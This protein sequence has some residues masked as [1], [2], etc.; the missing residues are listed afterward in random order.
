MSL[1][2]REIDLILE[3]LDLVS[4]RIDRIGQPDRFSLYLETYGHKR[5]QKIQ[6]GLYHNA[7]RLCRITEKPELPDT[8]PR[9][10][11]L[12]TARLRGFRI[13][14][15]SQPDQERIVHLV[16]S[17]GIETYNLWIRF[18]SGN[19]NII[20]TDGNNRIID[21]LF[22]KKEKK[23]IPG[24]VFLPDFKSLA[25][26][27]TPGPREIRDFAGFSDFN[28]C[29]NHFYN[30][31]DNR[32]DFTNR[33]VTILRILNKKLRARQSQMD[34]LREKRNIYSK[35]DELSLWG[36]LIGAS[37]HL[38]KKGE[39]SFQTVNY[40]NGETV[41]I[42]LKPELGPVENRDSFYSRS[43]KYRRGFERISR[44]IKQAESD[45]S[46]L[47]DLIEETE[48]ATELVHLP[49][50]D[51]FPDRDKPG[52]NLQRKEKTK[53]GLVFQ[54]GGFN[55]LVGR[56]SRENDELLR[57]YARGNDLWL[58]VRQYPGGFV[59]IKVRKGKSVPLETLLDAANL[60]LLYSSMKKNSEADV[61]YCEVKNLK[62]IKGGSPG[63]VLVQKDKNIHIKFD[64]ER[65]EQIRKTGS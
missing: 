27:K 47:T 2:C 54:S 31:S 20:L 25:G 60:A 63:Q 16:L 10:A 14:A 13:R 37:L 35:S 52:E 15:V 4:S 32:S 41:N 46:K 44:E 57:K 48:K 21:V 38:I 1:N 7:V 19:P 30:S 26:K 29:I 61:H 42:P 5:K 36:E 17:K 50:I 64:R 11:Q 34:S 53:T 9:F 33:K 24:E 43:K 18:W 22:R 8:P 56:N 28:S 6:I 3:E 59:I 23:E 55:I 40:H 12:L 45:I 49:E 62:R 39:S 51:D 58:H 65:I